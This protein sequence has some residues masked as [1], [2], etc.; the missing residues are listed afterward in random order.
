MIKRMAPW[1]ARHQ[2]LVGIDIGSTRVR[3]VQLARRRA[4]P[5]LVR[6]ASALLPAGAVL[7]GQ[8]ER[9]DQLGA[10]VRDLWRQCGIASRTVALALPAASVIQRRLSAPAG[11][12]EDALE[13]L[14]EAQAQR[15]L[16]F[17]RAEL[18]LDFGVRGALGAD[19]VELVLAAARR[20]QVEQRVAV[21]RA[22]GLR[23]SVMDIDTSAACRALQRTLAPADVDAAVALVQIGERS[24]QVAVLQGGSVIYEREHR[25]GGDA[26]EQALARYGA[27]PLVEAQHLMR[28]GDWSHPTLARLQRAALTATAEH[29]A[30][31]LQLVYGA[32]ACTRFARLY[33]AGGGALLPGLPQALAQ[34]MQIET[35]WA[36]PFLG[37]QGPAPALATGADYLVACGL[38]LDP[39]CD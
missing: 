31:A 6:W 24:T 29:V 13:A 14:V 26:L 20:D 16:P 12:D 27:M 5:T 35:C 9:V 19:S 22:A 37:M 23:A 10:C 17:A 8:V 39:C 36:A 33:L 2:G 7:E 4:G 1:G 30:R 32:G 11:L 3:L 34:L 38:A 28:S 15:V 18:S 25:Q 21:A